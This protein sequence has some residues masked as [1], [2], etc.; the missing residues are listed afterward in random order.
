[1]K[2]VVKSQRTGPPT[3]TK[4][5]GGLPEFTT[6]TIQ[7]V[8]VRGLRSVVERWRNEEKMPK[9]RGDERIK[10]KKQKDE[11]EEES[12]LDSKNKEIL[13]IVFLG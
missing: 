6:I 7:T 9:T 8:N 11:D 4:A 1:M 2:R 3:K 10:R 5:R 13:L 12:E